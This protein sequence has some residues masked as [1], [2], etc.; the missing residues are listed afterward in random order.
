MSSDKRAENNMAHKPPFVGVL[1]ENVY[2]SLKAIQ[3]V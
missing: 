2:V 3:H 1:D